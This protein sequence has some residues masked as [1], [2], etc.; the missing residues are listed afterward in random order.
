MA[1]QEPFV[2]AEVTDK[3]DFITDFREQLQ[4][5]QQKY[6]KREVECVCFLSEPYFDKEGLCDFYESF[7]FG[8]E[9]R[10]YK[11]LRRSLDGNTAMFR[12]I[13]KAWYERF[14]AGTSPNDP[15]PHLR[16]LR[17]AILRYTGQDASEGR[18]VADEAAD[19][20]RQVERDTPALDAQIN[21]L[22]SKAKIFR[23]QGL[24]QMQLLIEQRIA[25]LTD[26]LIQE[27]DEADRLELQSDQRR[28]NALEALRVRHQR[29]EETALDHRLQHDY[30][31]MTRRV[32]SYRT[33]IERLTR[34]MEALQEEQR[35]MQQQHP[36]FDPH[37]A[38][39]QKLRQMAER[40]RERAA[41][42]KKGKE[43]MQDNIGS[44]SQMLRK[45]G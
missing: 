41:H 44:C 26:Q 33:M 40:K 6:E 45:I 25:A 37:S 22:R 35:Q 7:T 2:P 4:L 21:V 29:Q 28:A 30:D 34:E 12:I 15:N 36:Q 9:D 18:T 3:P 31:S 39:K 24:H 14:L 5:L 11:L 13:S 16:D 23:R 27:R 8:K 10:I 42:K 19:L 38:A 43:Q 17:R 32:R 1:K 20:F